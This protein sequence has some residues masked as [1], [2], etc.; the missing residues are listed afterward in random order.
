LGYIVEKAGG[1]PYQ[2]ALK[3]RIASRIGLKNTYLGTGKTD[4]GKNEALSY[5][6]V[7]GWNEAAELDFSV[8]AGAGAILST[9][10]DMTKFIEALF[11]LKLVS[12]DSLKP[13]MTMRDDEG[14]GMEP[15]SFAGK[16]LYGHTGGSANSGAWLAYYPD[17]KL[18]LAYTTNAKIYPVKDIVS[19]I[20]DIYW[21]RPFQVPTFDRFDVS[22]EVLDRYVGVY[23]IPGTPAR[24][25]FT[26]N[27]TTLYFQPAGNSA[28]PI[29]AT[30]EDKFTI[31][32]FVV[33]EFDPAKG[34]MAI[35]RAGQKRVFTKEK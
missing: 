26:R 12:Q 18:A 21:N 35:T 33:F 17:E 2:E 14:M 30:A 19:G 3:E 15:F 10:T 22:T 5:N 34:E 32:P 24:L 23:T 31:A 1:K 13:M 7:G 6:Y 29:E 11:N 25:T 16:T 9:P 27:G 28:V 20:F 8:P 4:P